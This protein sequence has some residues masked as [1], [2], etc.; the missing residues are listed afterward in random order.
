[1]IM[2]FGV[3]RVLNCLV[4]DVVLFVLQHLFPGLWLNSVSTN[5]YQVPETPLKVKFYESFGL[6]SV[7]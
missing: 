6:F 3:I 1:M 7:D 2:S 4:F 5:S